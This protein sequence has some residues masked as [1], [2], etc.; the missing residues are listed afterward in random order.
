MLQI[1]GLITMLA[2]VEVQVLWTGLWQTQ[3]IDFSIGDLFEFSD[4]VELKVKV[5]VNCSVEKARQNKC[6][7]IPVV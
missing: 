1:S 2:E 7:L 3:I 4:Q 5:K 6:D